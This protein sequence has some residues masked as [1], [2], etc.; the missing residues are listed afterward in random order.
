MS[1]CGIVMPRKE[2]DI[3]DETESDQ[4]CLREYGHTGEHLTLGRKRF[5]WWNFEEAYC[6]DSPRKCSCWASDGG[7]IECF[8]YGDATPAE[9]AKY[10][11][12]LY[13]VNSL[14]VLQEPTRDE[15]P[16]QQELNLE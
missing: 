2:V 6:E 9:A 13:F 11:C 4:G 3:F 5:I 14:F 10:L 15:H 7:L 16:N 8:N 1:C 12:R